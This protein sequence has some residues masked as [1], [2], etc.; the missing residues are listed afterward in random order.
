[1]PNMHD[2]SQ[3][4]GGHHHHH[5][6]AAS[7]DANSNSLTQQLAAFQANSAQ[8]E[9][10]DPMAIVMNTLSNAGITASSNG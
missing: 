9:S 3:A 5:F 6:H 1:M 4:V 10:T 7:S 2:L 8:N